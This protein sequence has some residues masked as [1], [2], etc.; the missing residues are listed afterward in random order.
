MHRS[1]ALS[2]SP[3]MS[4]IRATAAKIE[5][6]GE[7]WDQNRPKEVIGSE[8]I[9]SVVEAVVDLAALR[10]QDDIHVIAVARIRN[11]RA[12]NLYLGSPPG[13]DSQRVHT[14]SGVGDDGEYAGAM[15][16]LEASAVDV[17]LARH[18][19]VVAGSPG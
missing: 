2:P 8:A 9:T 18:V 19:E 13:V 7:W 1:G 4:I 12:G 5:A 15:G 3:R 6:A 10:Q 11:S 14:G 17:V 16:I